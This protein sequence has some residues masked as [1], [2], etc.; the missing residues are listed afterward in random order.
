MKNFQSFLSYTTINGEVLNIDLNF[1]HRPT[2]CPGRLD[3][4]QKDAK[5]LKKNLVANLIQN[6]SDQSQQGTLVEYASALDL[7]RRIDLDE[8]VKL[9]EQLA[10]IYCKE[11]VHSVNENSDY[12]VDYKISIKYPKKIDCTVEE[13][14]KELKNLYPVINRRLVNQDRAKDLKSGNFKF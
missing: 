6:I 14:V 7:H 3:V 12:W 4:L 13:I 9:L 1:T 11:Y 5:A 10:Q 8:R 2:R